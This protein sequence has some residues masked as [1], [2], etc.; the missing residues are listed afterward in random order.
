M[1]DFSKSADDKKARKRREEMAREH[2]ELALDV[3]PVEVDQ[4]GGFQA[5]APRDPSHEGNGSSLPGLPDPLS[6]PLALSQALMERVRRDAGRGLSQKQEDNLLPMIVVLQAQS[7]A[8]DPDHQAHVPG[9][10]R[11][12]FWLK[13]SPVPIIKGKEGIL[14]VPAAMELAWVEW[15]PRTAGGGFI[16]KHREP[17]QDTIQIPDPKNPE[18]R[19]WV[20]KGNGHEMI[21]TRYRYGLVILE[22]LGMLPFV[23][24]FTSTGHTVCR[25]WE[26]TMNS[27]FIPGTNDATPALPV[28]TGSGPSRGPTPAGP[29]TRSTWPW[30][31][32]PGTRNTRGRRPSARR[33]RR[34]S[35]PWTPP[36]WRRL[37]WGHPRSPK[38]EKRSRFKKRSL[39]GS[40]ASEG[41]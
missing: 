5:L 23:I 31:G 36:R 33:S 26:T 19:K 27:L 16:A 25:G 30:R 4:R 34:R 22:G 40:W 21:E 2:P 9:A 38:L 41:G 15:R 11:G 6:G 24:P 37:G 13:N 32:R 29:G 14:F 10:E 18:K 7:P 35:C 1:V 39:A 12:A 3:D 8:C 28:A 17:P 20:R